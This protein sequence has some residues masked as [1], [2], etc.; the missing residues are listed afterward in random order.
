MTL[1]LPA[2]M[3]EALRAAA[4]EDHRSV[5]QEVAHAI[6]DYLA[7][8]ETEE[9]KS[10]PETLRA[11]AEARESVRAGDVVYGVEAA[12]ALVRDRDAS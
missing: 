3:D 8:R 10:D 7:R 11:L 6:E 9:I 12:R 2:E 5:Q 4:A 1:R